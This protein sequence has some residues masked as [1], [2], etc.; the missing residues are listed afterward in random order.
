MYLTGSQ[1]ASDNGFSGNTG[2]HIGRYA[3]LNDELGVPP[4]VSITSPA[5]GDMFLERRSLTIQ[6]TAEDDILVQSV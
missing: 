4:T 2:L 6:A 5:D 3:I 1:G